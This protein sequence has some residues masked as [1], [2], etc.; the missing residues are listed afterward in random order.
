[1][2]SYRSRSTCAP[3]MA[4]DLINNVYVENCHTC[5]HT[6]TCILQVNKRVLPLIRSGLNGGSMYV[7][8]ILLSSLFSSPDYVDLIKKKLVA[9][10]KLSTCTF[11]HACTL[12]LA[13][14]S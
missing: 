4:V 11:M 2:Q 12:R 7:H 5:M 10:R 9:C 3:C 6:C 8:T 14:A 13:H 1:M